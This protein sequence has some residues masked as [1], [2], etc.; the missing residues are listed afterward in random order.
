MDEAIHEYFNNASLPDLL[1]SL[2]NLVLQNNQDTV[3]ERLL[4]K[5]FELKNEHRELASKCLPF[6]V[7]KKYLNEIDI[8]KV[9][10]VSR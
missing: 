8:A 7:S 5:V 4:E 3:L 9:F 6:L 1:E 2:E 10:C